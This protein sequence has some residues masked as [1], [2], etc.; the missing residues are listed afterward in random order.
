MV[1]HELQLRMIINDPQQPRQMARQHQRVEYQAVS[2]H[3]RQ[4]RRQDRAEQPV[5]IGN[6]ASG[7][8]LRP[9][10]SRVRVLILTGKWIS[11]T[12][13]I[14]A[15]HDGLIANPIEMPAADCGSWN[16]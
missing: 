5:V 4:Q 7:M 1:Q 2:S 3:R 11:G 6:V 10:L 14:R 15:P 13:I 12:E 16:C 9:E 8:P